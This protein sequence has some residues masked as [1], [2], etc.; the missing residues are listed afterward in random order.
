MKIH[1][2]VETI[3]EDVN[4]LVVIVLYENVSWIEDEIVFKKDVKS[5]EN[6]VK[7]FLRDVLVEMAFRSSIEINEEAVLA[8]VWERVLNIVE[9][10]IFDNKALLQRKDIN[11]ILKKGKI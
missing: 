4:V 11:I 1:K 10:E 7:T 6:A 2:N 8:I 3:V 5:M 9:D